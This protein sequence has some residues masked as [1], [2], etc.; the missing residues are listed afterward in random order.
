MPFVFLV[1]YFAIP[2]ERSGSTAFIIEGFRTWKKVNDEKRCAFL[3][4]IGNDSNSPH[5]TAIQRCHDLAKPSQHIV[6]IFEKQTS[7]TITSNRLRLKTSIDAIRWLTFQGCAFR[8]NDE[9]LQSRNRGNFLELLE[10][11]SSYNKEV[12]DVVLQNAPKNACY[13]SPQ[14]QKEILSIFASKVQGKIRS[15]IGDSK[16]CI[17][18]DE[19]RDESKRE[20]MSIVL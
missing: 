17:I 16:F 11:L 2:S 4:H 14:I 5:R 3:A 20:Q 13:T 19:A 10:I 7:Q 9:S 18:V 15:E 8:G 12:K 1:I 6:R